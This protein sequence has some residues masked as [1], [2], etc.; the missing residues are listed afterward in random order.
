MEKKLRNRDKALLL[1]FLVIGLILRLDFVIPVDFVIDADEA[2]VGLMAKHISEGREIPIFYYGQSYMGSFEAI[3]AAQVFKLYGPSSAALKA[4]PLFF[5]VLFIIVVFYISYFLGG[6]RTAL[7]G[8]ALAAIPPCPLVVWSA[9]AR[10]GFI[11]ILVVGGLAVLF[12]IHWLRKGGQSSARTFLI[13]ALLG[14]G[15]WINNQIVYFMLPI[16]LF[17]ILR[18]QS[19]REA[20]RHFL[21]GMTAFFLGGLPF[22]LYNLNHDFAS[23]GMFTSASPYEVS[24]H[25]SGLFSISIPT[26]LGA[27]RFWQSHDIFPLAT[28]LYYLV[29]GALLA[30][31]LFYRRR[32]AGS[33]LKFGLP[34]DPGAELLL[35]L[36]FSVLSV[37]V[38]SSFGYL[39]Q[40]PRYLLP[41]YVAII[42]LTALAISIAAQYSRALAIILLFGV[43]GLN[44]LS[45][46]TSGRS[47]PG[48][49]FVYKEQ[50]VA[51]SHAELIDWL[52]SRNISWVRTNYWI[53]YRLA[54]ETGERI[55]FELFREPGQL[56]IR[57]YSAEAKKRG[58]D[59]M[60]LVLVPA[61]SEIVEEALRLLNFSF[62]AASVGGY[63]V[64][65]D[66]VP[67]PRQLT[68]IESAML[69]T[70]A[71][72][73]QE[74]SLQAIDEDVGTR[75]RSARPQAP[76][77]YFKINLKNPASLGGL[78]YYLGSW[79]QDFPRS[80][81]IEV[82]DASGRNHLVMSDRQY[83]SLRYLANDNDFQVFFNVQDAVSVTLHQEGSDAVFDWSI[84]EIDL[85]KAENP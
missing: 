24:K 83:R 27:K 81:R 18:L 45:C 2:I 13:G 17:F 68:P 53:G 34:D 39:V 9:K 72:L 16:G 57:E 40:A 43:L 76:G 1:L 25:I 75:W 29:Y 54:F 59:T 15:W 12:A 55:R 11:E 52:D 19:W 67:A 46:Y 70:D 38:V 65:Y 8:A 80:L 61:Q 69:S 26:I 78:R 14:F 60:P 66:L 41:V 3:L 20:L 28:G 32:Q 73:M 44:L 58:V 47:I 31:V 48:E 62:Q 10:G 23:F 71:G 36:L 79:P 5:S 56:R 42:P 30:T 50:R 63:R 82:T 21:L 85:L 7:I 37:F 33:L 74:E 6:R 64:L 84:A 4:V 22:W 49:P 35:L 51:R 77:M